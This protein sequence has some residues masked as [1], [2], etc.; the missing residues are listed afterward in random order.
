MNTNII[1]LKL[2]YMAKRIET[3]TNRLSELKESGSVKEYNSY[4]VGQ[5]SPMWT[6]DEYL[7]DYAQQFY[8]LIAEKYDVDSDM[9]NIG[10]HVENICYVV[11]SY[12]HRVLDGSIQP[13]NEVLDCDIA[14]SKMVYDTLMKII[15]EM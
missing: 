2:R 3:L 9:Y 6:I 10:Y 5:D 14:G 13:N 8:S 4:K 15:E 11:N 7:G 12:Y 1:K